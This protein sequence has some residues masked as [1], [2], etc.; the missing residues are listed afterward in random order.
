[1]SG[2]NRAVKAEITH[3]GK[4]GAEAMKLM[5]PENL[6]AETGRSV[7]STSVDPKKIAN[8]KADYLGKTG[9]DVTPKK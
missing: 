4:T 6:R 8:D 7:H 9:K 2:V 5:S 3:A 1:M